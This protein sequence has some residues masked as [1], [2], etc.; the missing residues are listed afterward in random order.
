MSVKLLEL[1]I[2][3]EFGDGSLVWQR[4]QH[5]NDAGEIARLC[6]RGRDVGRD[7]AGTNE[8][9]RGERLSGSM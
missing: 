3:G 8:S 2:H 1:A 6:Q 9:K 4:K 7:K 5:G